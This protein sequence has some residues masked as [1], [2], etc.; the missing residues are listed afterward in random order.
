M[1]KY[2][3]FQTACD[4]AFALFVVTWFVARHVLYIIICWSIHAD[5]PKT[6][7]YGCYSSLTGER[8]SSDGGTEVLR[9]IMQPFQNPGGAI[10]FNARIR[11]YFLAVLLFLQGIMLMWFA[12][13]IRVVLKV[14]NGDGADDSRSDDDEEKD[15][16]QMD[17][18]VVE[19]KPALT[20]KS[21][22]EHYVAADEINCKRRPSSNTRYRGRKSGTTG[23]ALSDR[24]ELLGRI[25]C[26]KPS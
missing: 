16:E 1:L 26:D 25:G 18:P 19:V 21:V 3:G 20:T 13:I 11:Y 5:V 7:L 17:K 15:V 6:M 24:K 23:G 10:C 12:M 9:H 4:G 14:L 2:S 22:V 8:Y